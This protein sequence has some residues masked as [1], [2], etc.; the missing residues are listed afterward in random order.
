MFKQVSIPGKGLGLV[1]T[2]E[3][4]VGTTII[5][6]SPLIT[7]E[8]DGDGFSTLEFVNKFRHLT[9]DQKIQVLSLHDPGPNSV[10]GQKIPSAL[11][12]YV[13]DTEKKAL[14]IFAGNS[15]ALCGH[16]EMNVNKSGLYKTISRINH[17]CAPN[18]VWS[19]IQRDES[20]SVKQVRVC[21]KVKEGEEIL[22]S[23]IMEFDKFPSKAERQIALRDWNFICRCDVCSLTG[24]K[25]VKSE[26]ARTKITYLNIAQQSRVD[27]GLLK[28]AL[29][30]AMEKQKIMK[31]IKR[32][33]ILHIP[34]VMVDCC[35]LAVHC[36]LQDSNVA[37]L[38]KKAKNMS[39]LYG[40]LFIYNYHNREKKI[41][42]IQHYWAAV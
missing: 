34:D 36:K 19:W 11:L 8:R 28:L 12:Q 20:K 27:S 14:R 41:E 26:Y 35:E 25:L 9:G 30:D 15:I 10:Q 3:L 17:S 32:E 4:P 39:E 38:M 24:H 40:D 21:R 6:E 37:E 1:A 31:S 16:P 22:A 42:R 7:V 5:E 29:Q 33:M 2:S 23:Y 13:D 18:V